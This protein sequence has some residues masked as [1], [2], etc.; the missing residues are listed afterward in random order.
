MKPTCRIV[1]LT[2][3]TL[4]ASAFAQTAPAPAPAP[5]PPKVVG[6]IAGHP[7]WPAAK[8]DDV[9]SLQAIIGALYN[10]ISGAKGQQRDWDRFRSLFIPDAA[11]IPT[12]SSPPAPG[13]PGHAD[14]ILLSVD[15]YI[16][17]SNA[18]MTKD[19]FFERSIHNE[20]QQFGNIVEVWSTYES[21]HSPEDP[22]PFA[23]GINSL[24]LL[25]DGDRYWI[26]NIFWDSETPNKP[27][28][29]KFL[30]Q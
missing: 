26:V 28:P 5:A 6:S 16:Q 30:P 9:N 27:I 17:R 23:R 20:V 21:R 24:Q 14:A 19:G 10:V 11:L 1:T 15:E 2:L 12:I 13:P 8:P 18:V 22:K 7:N 25:K 29:A 4:S 3:L